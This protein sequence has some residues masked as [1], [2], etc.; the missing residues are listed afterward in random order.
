MAHDFADEIFRQTNLASESKEYLTAREQ[1]RRAEIELMKHRELVAAMRRSLPQGPVVQDYELIEGPAALDSDQPARTTKLS[2]LFST[3]DRPLVIYHLMFG[4][5]QVKPCPMCTLWVDAA[6]GVAEHM[7]QK[8]DFAVVAAA[9]LEAL[10]GHARSRGWNKLRLLSAGDSS[11]K[12]DLGSEDSEGR[13]DSAVSVFIKDAEG[14]VRHT[15]TTHPRMSPKI[16]E[17]GIDL[18]VPLWHYLDLT[19]QGR[20]DW[21]P[22]L[23][24]QKKA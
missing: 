5:K 6:N 12:F 10:R 24:Y 8:F 23:A 4:K 17:R 20:G 14:E 3:P 1:L 9:D 13:Q 11:F 18:L 21:Y 19:P 2:E 16:S 7:S 15:Y 22:S